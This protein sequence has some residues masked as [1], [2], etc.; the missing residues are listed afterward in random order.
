MELQA[1]TYLMVSNT[2][3]LKD[4]VN[5]PRGTFCF[6]YGFLFFDCHY[7]ISVPKHFNEMAHRN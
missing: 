7:E 2:F 3:I 5:I 6:L 4:S 1:V